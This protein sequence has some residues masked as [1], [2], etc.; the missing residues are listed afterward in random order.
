MS[1]FLS[2]REVCQ[3]LRDAA[4]GVLPFKVCEPPAAS[5]LVAV[6]IEGWRLLLLQPVLEHI[7]RIFALALIEA[8][9]IERLCSVVV[10]F[11]EER[12]LIE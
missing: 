11:G 9:Q 6:E 3:R 5:G 1:S 4:L 2:A 10:V 8:E 7:T 12:E